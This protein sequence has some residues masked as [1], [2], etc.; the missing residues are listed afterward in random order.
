MFEVKYND[1]IEH[2]YI[3]TFKVFYM[4]GLYVSDIYEAKCIINID[5][6]SVYI[7]R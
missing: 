3:N 6:K 4:P 5:S 7:Y 2:N 1:F